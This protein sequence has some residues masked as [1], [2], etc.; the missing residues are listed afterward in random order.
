MQANDPASAAAAQPV[1]GAPE[2][3]VA[4]PPQAARSGPGLA[5]LLATVLL[6]FALAHFISYLYRTV[7]A[8][9]YPDLAHDLGLAAG[10]LGLLTSAYFLTF[11]AAQLPIGV[12]L[13]RFGP[14][15]VQ[16]PM[17]LVAAAG[18]VLF[19]RAQSLGELVLARGMIGLGVAG[20]LMSAIKAGSLW[21][22]Q[23]RLPLSTAIL[24]AVGGMGAMASTTPMQWA[25]GLTD[26]R[27]AF[28]ALAAGTLLVSALIFGVV[29]EHPG[30]K[31]QTRL[32]DM[33][34]TVGELYRAWSFWRLALYTLFAHA[35]YM[36]VQGLW[37]APWLRDVGHLARPQVAQVLFAGTVAMVAGSLFFGWITDAVQKYGFKPVLVC[38]TGTVLFLLFQLLMVLGPGTLAVHPLVVAVG[39]SFFGTATTMN[40]AIVAQSVP[41]H[42]TGRVSTSFNLLVFLLA[43]GVQWGLG[44][45]I[46]QWIPHQGQYPQAAYRAALGLNL[47]LQLPG[48]VLWLGFRP[49]RRDCRTRQG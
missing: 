2:S 15:K 37:M 16:G 21:L 31:T 19:A 11:A 3:A 45:L 18:A 12:A 27:G 8:V 14:R 40:Y 32:R 41:G 29:P 47:L 10:S 26:W 17:L 9:V 44:L 34:R 4:D 49:W 24:L 30:Q 33:V 6:P 36:A 39:F 43:F 7:N 5:V 46:T 35:T 23:E 25:L 28:L 38:G 48:I 42:L 20:S 22:P 13:D 1:T